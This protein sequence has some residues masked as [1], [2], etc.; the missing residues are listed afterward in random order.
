MIHK[1]IQIKEFIVKEDRAGRLRV[2]M[3]KCTAPS[4]LNSLEFTQECINKDGEV[5]F[6]STYNFFMTDKEIA[7]LCKG[8]LT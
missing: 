3:W 6:S 5:D 8:L 1:S 7:T 2:K 4:E